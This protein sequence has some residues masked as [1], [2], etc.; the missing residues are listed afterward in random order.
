MVIEQV[1]SRGDFL[2]SKNNLTEKS[3]FKSVLII[4]LKK[5]FVR[6]YPCIIPLY[7][8]EPLTLRKLKRKYWDS[9]KACYRRRMEKI[10]W[11]LEMTNEFL[12]HIEEKRMFLINILCKKDNLI[13]HILIRSLVYHDPS[14]R[15]MA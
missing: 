11:S 10:N 14:E 9:F 8:S 3:L 7:S 1:E 6:C 13:I 2:W 12:E 4:L 15:Q 5:S